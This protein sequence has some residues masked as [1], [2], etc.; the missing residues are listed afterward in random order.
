MSY[1]E[2]H[3]DIGHKIAKI[4]ISIGRRYTRI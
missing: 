1:L 3:I 4:A 2:C